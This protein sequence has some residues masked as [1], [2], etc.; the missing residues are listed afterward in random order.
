MFGKIIK[1]ELK[2][3]LKSP[4]LYVYAVIMLALAFFVMAEVVGVFDTGTASVVGITKMNAPVVLASILSGLTQILYFLLPSIVGSSIYKDYKY[5]MYQVIFSYPFGK[6]DYLLAKFLSSTFIAVLIMF[7]AAFGIML[8]TFM[9]GANQE[10]LLP[11][12]WYNYLQPFFILVIPNLIFFGAIVFGVVT[13]SRNIFVGFIAVLILIVLQGLSATFLGELETKSIGALLDPFGTNA[14]SYEIEYWTVADQNTRRI[15]FEGY[16]LYNRLL[17]SG[18]GIAIF[19]LI[20]RLFEFHHQGFSFKSSRKKGESVTKSN[21]NFNR[22][23]PVPKVTLDFSFMRNLKIGWKHSNFELKYILKNWAFISIALV[24]VLISWLGLSFGNSIYGTDTL[25]VTR[26]I[27][28]NILGSISLFNAILIFL[29]TGMLLHRGRIAHMDQLLDATPL[30]NWVNLF[31]KSVAIVKLLL[32]MYGVGLLI[33]MLYQTTQGYFNYEIGLYLTRFLAIDLLGWIPYILLSLLIHSLIKNYIVGFVTLLALTIFLGFF[34]SF[35]IEQSIFNFN[36]RTGLNYSDMSGF[37]SNVGSFVIYRL[38]WLLLGL[39]FYVLALLFYRR[40]ITTNIKERFQHASLNSQLPHKLVLTLSLVAFFSLG[41][42]IY[43]VNNVQ[44]ER[45][46]SKDSEIRQANFEKTYAFLKQT[47]QPRIVSANINLDLVPETRDFKVNGT[48]I[49]KNK[50][51]VAVDSIILTASFK[52]YPSEFTLNREAF[53]TTNDTTYGLQIYQLNDPLLPGDSLELVF[54]MKNKPNTM[55]RNNSPVQYNGTFMNNGIFPNFGYDENYEISNNDVRKKYDLAP[56]DRMKS[57]MDSTALGN[58]YI[59]SDADWI[60]FETVVSTS[61]NQIAIAPGYLEK[62]WEE[63]GRRY[64]HYKMNDKMLN[65]YNYMS[66][67]YEVMED[68]VEGI[69]LQIFYHKG[70]EFNLD[71]LMNGMKLSLPY[72]N[73]N[74]SPYQFNQLRIIEFPSSQGTFAQAFAN[75]VPFSEAIGFIADVDDDKESVDYPFTVTAHEVAHQWWA[76]QVIGANVRGA[77]MMSE[78]L[79]EYS[80]LKVL[81]QRYGAKQMRRFL[82][83]ALDK[84]LSSRKFESQKE[85]PLIFNENQQYI[86]YNKGSLVMYAMSDYLGEENFNQMLSEYIDEVAF[87]EPPYTTS[88]EFLEH[89]KRAT[90]DSLQYLVTDMFETITL[91]DNKVIEASVEEKAENGTFK[92]SMNI[93]VAK[94]KTSPL[95]EELYEDEFGNS[96]NFV[97]KENDSIRSFPLKDYIEIGIFGEEEIDGK[98]EEKILYLQKL[99]FTEIDNELEILVDEKPKS[100]GIDPYNKLIDR[101]SFDNRK[102]L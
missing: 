37:G 95:G 52:S 83:D 45:I 47:P 78:S 72:Y 21:F 73:K 80:S 49:L 75:T 19:L 43:Y 11:F 14:L 56:K 59:S 1:F 97:A 67:T 89:V 76:H 33:G 23:I 12:D 98:K 64:F 62:E 99:R 70:H 90:P 60:D 88:L 13:F 3:W 48:Y 8:A 42:Y 44:N 20:Y 2:Y 74:F 71:R 50:N 66:A 63:D 92:V 4:L 38:Y 55:L 32:V 82:K 6:R 96:L 7:F 51:T 29:F 93:Q 25:P 81:E 18:I 87:Q 68:E 10:M 101:N 86:H 84:Y 27:S 65:F 94:Y 35:G 31:S 91:Y 77:T 79:A 34:S 39:V 102:K 26:V 28:G 22:N 57:P 24:G 36:S 53:L 40:G 54:N 17:W 85:L 5:D 30:P 69:A 46:S 9:P 15:P 41:S 100:V 58:T 16:I 61:P